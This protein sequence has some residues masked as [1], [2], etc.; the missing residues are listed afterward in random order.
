MKKYTI[1]YHLQPDAGDI[2]FDIMARDFDCAVAYAKDYRKEAFTIEEATQRNGEVDNMN[3]NDIID[4][5][6]EKRDSVEKQITDRVESLLHDIAYAQKQTHN[7]P[8]LE[9]AH[10]LRNY[11][12]ISRLF[13]EYNAFATAVEKAKMIV[14]KNEIDAGEGGEQH[15]ES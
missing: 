2:K 3:N 6:T 9:I 1:T 15:V 5:L 8:A 11:G 7:A 14:W 12:D 4:M 10:S 13:G